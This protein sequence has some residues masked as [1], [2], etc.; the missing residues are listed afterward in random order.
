MSASSQPRLVLIGMPETGK[1][2]FLGAFWG[3][4]QSPLEPAVREASFAGDRSYI[5]RLAEQVARGQEIDRTGVDTNEA[6]AVEL[7]FDGLGSANVL[8]PDTSGESLRVLV[9]SQVW[10]PRLHDACAQASAVALFVHPAR[11]RVPQPASL[12]EV[13]QAADTDVQ[14]EA[15]VPF[16]VHD[17]AAT[18]AELIDVFENVTELCRERWP[19]RM[20]VIVS[21][22][23]R[24]DGDMTPY[25]WVQ[26]RLPGLLSTIESNPELAA[27]EVFGMSAQGGSLDERDEL[28]AKGEICDRVYARD[29]SGLAVSLI[30][31]V[32]WAIF[33][34]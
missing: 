34:E 31:P 32:R 14:E 2:T 9:E 28:L 3:L 19:I 1:S 4:V 27:L 22:W 11:L 16:D 18:A 13:A 5:Q 21:A 17:H 33:G 23:D 8:I 29:R 7:D 15:V 12:L 25:Q 24:V 26:A 30:A 6:M 20:A 10:H